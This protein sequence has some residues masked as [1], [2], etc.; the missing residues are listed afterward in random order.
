M[1]GRHPRWDRLA[2]SF[3][4]Y[5][6]SAFLSYGDRNAGRTL[7]VE[8]TDGDDLVGAIPGWITEGNGHP[9]LEPTGLLGGLGLA[10]ARYVVLG[11]PYAFFGEFM[12]ATP[13]AAP[14][15][16]RAARTVQ[17]REDAVGVI[18]LH[19]SDGSID[20]VVTA[21]A[22]PPL[23]VGFHAVIDV[24]ASFDEYLAALPSSRRTKIRRERNAFRSAGL[25]PS[26][27]QIPDCLPELSSLI[28]RSEARHGIRTDSATVAAGLRRQH[29]CFPDR[30]RVFTA[31]GPSGE[32][33]G[34]VVVHLDEIS[35]HTRIVGLLNERSPACEYFNLGYYQ[36]L[37]FAI[38]S[39]RRR[40]DLGMEA[41]PAKLGRGARLEP[42]W[43]VDLSDTPLWT[44]DDARHWNQS[45]IDALIRLVAHSPNSSN[46]ALVSHLQ[47]IINEPGG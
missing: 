33:L 42:R 36:P 17:Q 22:R 29:D 23:L 45:K 13:D 15:L 39:N 19:L 38:G 46:T 11:S 44:P 35:V 43:A 20:A 31:R 32:L 30:A 14:L 21:S 24:P 1:M 41:Y 7:S 10:P 27:E 34:G 2:A 3:S 9:Y 26:V 8:A 37:L 4:F 12:L 40:I 28:A 5:S 16:V 25:T 47:K 18:G 6:G